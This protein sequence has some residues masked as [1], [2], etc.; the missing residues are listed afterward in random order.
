MSKQFHKHWKT[1]IFSKK[2][3]SIYFSLT[4]LSLLT[5][6]PAN[7]PYCSLA[8]FTTTLTD[9]SYRKKSMFKILVHN[10]K[11][12]RMN[13]IYLFIY[14]FIWIKLSTLKIQ[15]L[16]GGRT[17]TFGRPHAARG[18]QVEDPVLSLG[19]NTRRNYFR[20]HQHILV[21]FVC[22]RSGNSW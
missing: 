2:F 3:G 13:F 19:K 16:F 7:I 20:I 12:F 15:K 14:L 17:K 11:Y 8:V 5:N 22:W 4:C 6:Y 1:F 10:L 21:T 9:I 18:R